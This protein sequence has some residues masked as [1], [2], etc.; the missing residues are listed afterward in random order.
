MTLSLPLL[1]VL[2]L[3]EYYQT[4]PNKN[5]WPNLWHVTSI[6]VYNITQNCK[7]ILKIRMPFSKIISTHCVILIKI[8]DRLTSKFFSIQDHRSRFSPGFSVE[9]RLA[10]L[11]VPPLGTLL[12]EKLKPTSY[13]KVGKVGLF[14]EDCIFLTQSFCTFYFCSIVSPPQMLRILRV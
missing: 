8:I 2:W 4:S 13:L 7:Q 11:S 9:P 5:K 3:E 10:M 6:L 1:Y 14:E 12:R